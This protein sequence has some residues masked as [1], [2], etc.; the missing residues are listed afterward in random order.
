MACEAVREA[1]E[2]IAEQ[3]MGDCHE[4]GSAVRFSFRSCFVSCSGDVR[5]GVSLS[6]R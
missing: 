1:C 4:D 2:V 3:L 5:P 6:F